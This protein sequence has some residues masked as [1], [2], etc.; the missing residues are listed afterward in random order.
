MMGSFSKVPAGDIPPARF[1][2]LGTVPGTILV[3]GADESM[4]GISQPGTRR[5]PLS[6]FDDNLAGKAGD[7]AINVIGPGDDEALLELGGAV[8]F[9]QALK[10]GAGGVG[11]AATGDKDKIG[12]IALAAGVSGQRIKVKPIRYDQAV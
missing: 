9:G 12:A 7:G 6:G 1:V 10:S 2:K 5:F 4:W 11:V 8:A 3:C